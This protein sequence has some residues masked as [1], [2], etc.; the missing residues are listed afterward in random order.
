MFLEIARYAVD[1]FSQEYFNKHVSHL[2]FLYQKEKNKE[3]AIIFSKYVTKFME[4]LGN[5]KDEFYLN[6][7]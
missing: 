5:R 7:S 3:V 1:E 2:L 6:S 4:G